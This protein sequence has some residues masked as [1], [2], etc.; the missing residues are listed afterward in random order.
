[1]KATERQKRID[2]EAEVAQQ[3]SE[4]L[5]PV[6]PYGSVNDRPPSIDAFKKKMK[7]KM[8]Q[9]MTVNASAAKY[10]GMGKLIEGA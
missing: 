9:V 6:V 3:L 8:K 1:M 10:K 7:K 4:K 2:R 5:L